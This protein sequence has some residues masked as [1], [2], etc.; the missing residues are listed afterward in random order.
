[1]N[2]SNCYLCLLCDIAANAPSPAP[3]PNSPLAK[4]LH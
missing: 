3:A 4:P 2:S 1:M